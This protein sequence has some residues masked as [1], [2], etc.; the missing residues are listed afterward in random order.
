[1]KLV[2]MVMFLCFS[3]GV[4]ASDLAQKGL[5]LCEKV[6]SCAVIELDNSGVPEGMRPV[7]MESFDSACNDL[8]AQFEVPENYEQITDLAGACMDS[9][10]ELNCN[11]LMAENETSACGDYYAAAE[12]YDL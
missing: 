4:Y 12:Q 9:M 2:V 5:A 7:M 6:K 3:C 10:H 1:M 11:D 8:R